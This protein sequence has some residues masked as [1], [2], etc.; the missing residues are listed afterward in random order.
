[1]GA[2]SDSSLGRFEDTGRGESETSESSLDDEE[3]DPDATRRLFFIDREELLIRRLF[4]VDREEYVD[5]EELEDESDE[6]ESDEE[7]EEEEEEVE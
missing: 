2:G 7:E 5:D 3:D 1:V 6:D 4:F